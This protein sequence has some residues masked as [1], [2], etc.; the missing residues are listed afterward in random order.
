MIIKSPEKED[1][2]EENT[3]GQKAVTFRTS[4]IGVRVKE[5]ATERISKDRALSIRTFRVK[6]REDEIN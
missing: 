1:R 6:A 5:S 4:H 3:G 2:C